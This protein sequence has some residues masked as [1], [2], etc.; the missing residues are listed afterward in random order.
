[1]QLN[2]F[3]DALFNGEL[4]RQNALSPKNLKNLTLPMLDMPT[5]RL[6]AS[7]ASASGRAS[8]LSNLTT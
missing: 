1:M 6:S 4:A 7:T 3:T 8:R 5:D 2:N